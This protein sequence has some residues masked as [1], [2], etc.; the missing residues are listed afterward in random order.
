[1]IVERDSGW[2]QLRCETCDLAPRATPLPD[3]RLE[4]LIYRYKRTGPLECGTCWQYRRRHHGEARTPKLVASAIDLAYRQSGR[5]LKARTVPLLRKL[6]LRTKVT[7]T[8][9][10]WTGHVNNAGYGTFSVRGRSTL[11]HRLAYEEMVGPIPEGFDVDHLCHTRTCLNPKHLEPISH[12]ENIKRR[13]ARRL[14][15]T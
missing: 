8:C 15:D 14:T 3:G 9:W 11:V 1:M 13:D 5:R 2:E 4:L 7:P 12:A 10:L 6:A